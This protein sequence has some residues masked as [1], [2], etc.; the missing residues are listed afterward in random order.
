MSRGY[1]GPDTKKTIAK[2]RLTLPP[3]VYCRRSVEADPAYALA[4]FN[5]GNLFDE[6]GDRTQA[7]LHYMVAIRLNPNYSDAHYNLALLYQGSGQL[8][9]AVRH[10]KIYL[11]LDAGSPWAAIARQELDKLREATIVQGRSATT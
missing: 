5:L 9:R 7:L 2:L 11:K 10:W 1:P 6:I 8:L 3:G 4:H